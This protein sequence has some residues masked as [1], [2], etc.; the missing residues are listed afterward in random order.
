MR[1]L[2]HCRRPVFATAVLLIG[3]CWWSLPASAATVQPAAAAAHRGVASCSGPEI[4]S[5]AFKPSTV[6]EGAKAD[7]EGSISNC[8]D[9]AFTGSLET[10]GRLVCEVVDPISSTVHLP[11][12]GGE[13]FVILYHAPDCTG[14]GS[15]TGRL[16]DHSGKTLSTRIARLTIVS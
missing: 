4:T 1:T 12:H 11:A 16:L 14:H 7:L 2:H 8:T 3:A 15:I 10:F 6:K 13:A 5:F 9:K